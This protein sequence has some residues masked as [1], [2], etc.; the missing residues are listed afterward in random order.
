MREG[1][2]DEE[3]EGWRKIEK[4]EWEREGGREKERERDH[5]EL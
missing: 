1:G 2:T 5:N 3:R 4:V